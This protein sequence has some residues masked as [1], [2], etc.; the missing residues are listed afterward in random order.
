[1]GDSERATSDGL[2]TDWPSR[3]LKPCVL[4]VIATVRAFVTLMATLTP[5]SKVDGRGRAGATRRVHIYSSCVLDPE[6]YHLANHRDS[7]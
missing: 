7:E 5:Y 6:E 4:S 3:N 1:M 2:G